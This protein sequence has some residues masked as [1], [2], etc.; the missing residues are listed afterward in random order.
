MAHCT[1][2]GEKGT[3]CPDPTRSVC[4]VSLCGLVQPHSPSQKCFYSTAEKSKLGWFFFFFLLF[5]KTPKP[6]PVHSPSRNAAHAERP[7]RSLV[8]QLPSRRVG[9]SRDGVSRQ[10]ASPLLP[11]HCV[12]PLELMEGKTGAM[13]APVA[14]LRAPQPPGRSLGR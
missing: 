6:K 13:A 10:P 5:N 3:C 14:L 1:N 7:S 12:A 4:A 9:H 2:A 11:S 8:R